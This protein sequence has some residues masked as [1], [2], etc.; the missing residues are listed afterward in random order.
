VRIV[1]AACGLGILAC[2]AGCG[3]DRTADAAAPADSPAPAPTRSIPAPA[4]GA[5]PAVS[6]PAPGPAPGPGPLPPRGKV[7]PEIQ[8]VA[9]RYIAMFYAG[10]LD[11]LYEKFS[12]DMKEGMPLD[13][14]RLVRDTVREKFGNETRVVAEETA[15]KDPYRAFVRWAEFDGTEGLVEFHWRL[16]PDDSIAGLWMNPANKKLT[17]VGE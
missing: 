9:H 2:A 15:A 13:K 6:A 7:D 14:L 10:E 4:P 16:H 5:P 11:A 8:A 1:L 3:G 12:P 17:I